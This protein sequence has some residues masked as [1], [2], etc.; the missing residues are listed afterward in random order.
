MFWDH[1]LCSLA[2]GCSVA[3]LHYLTSIPEAGP[4]LT[5]DL[6]LHSLNEQERVLISI[7]NQSAH[8]NHHLLGLQT[9]GSG[10]ASYLNTCI[11]SVATGKTER[12]G[13]ESL[14]INA[15]GR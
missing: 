14:I 12:G 10:V 1:K 3:T 9:F 5:L 2:S 6:V 11:M 15:N 13:K 4:A 8:W 7:S